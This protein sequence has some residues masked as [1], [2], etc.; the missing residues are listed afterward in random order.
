MYAV[1]EIQ[2]D[3]HSDASVV[4]IR[5]SEEELS[6]IQDILLDAR[7][8]HAS[9]CRLVN[10]GADEMLRMLAAPPPPEEWTDA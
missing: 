5:I 10:D 9:L 7:A 2:L 8:E 1:L 6:Y 4:E 3:I